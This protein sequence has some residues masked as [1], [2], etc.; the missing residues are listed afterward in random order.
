MD[1]N[2]GEG[3]QRRLSIAELNG[4][5]NREDVFEADEMQLN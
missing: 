5:L 2:V 3:A 4:V 1:L